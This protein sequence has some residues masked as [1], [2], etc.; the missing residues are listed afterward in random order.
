M[1]KLRTL[2]A[3]FQLG[4]RLF[5]P[6][7]RINSRFCQVL[8]ARSG[9]AGY[10]K[11][12]VGNIETTGQPPK[13]DVAQALILRGSVFVHLDPRVEGVEVPR[14][15][16]TDSQL[17]LQFGLDLPL[18][19]PDLRIDDAGIFGTLSFNRTPFACSVPHEAIF[20]ITD[21]EGRG[22]LW[23]EDMPAELIREVE[24]ESAR[25]DAESAPPRRKR[26]KSREHEE[27]TLFTDIHDAHPQEARAV[28]QVVRNRTPARKRK[29]TLPP[30]LR[31]VK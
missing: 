2:G 15:L 4:N 24:L 14:W 31:L 5:F 30:Y 27:D 20:A 9:S 3:R 22:I 12:V 7:I 16:G 28:K 10:R 6:Y 13:K 18:P 1:K 29:R 26:R 25:Q 23:K 8:L 11:V 21:E 19:I 17:V